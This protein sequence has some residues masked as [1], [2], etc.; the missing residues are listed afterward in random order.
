M[1]RLKAPPARLSAPPRAIGYATRAEAERARDK[2]RRQSAGENLR[3]LYNTKRWRDP[4]TGVRARV[5][6]RDGWCCQMC[7]VT[8]AGKRPA[9]TSPVVDHVTPHKGNLVLFWDEGNL[10]ALCKRCH[11]TEKQRQERAAEALG[12]GSKV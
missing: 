12:G 9:P 3:N 6:V 7:G 1:G 2:V 11:D 10:Q 5:L 8:L 4:V